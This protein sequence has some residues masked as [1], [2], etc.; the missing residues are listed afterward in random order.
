LEYDVDKIFPLLEEAYAA[1]EGPELEGKTILLKPNI[2][3]DDDPSKAVITHPVF[4]EAVIRFLWSKKAGKIYL[5]DAPAMHAPSFKPRK[6]GIFEMCERTGVEW[7][8]F[9][10]KS[11]SCP[12]PSGKVPITS[13]V[14]E[15][16]YIFSLPKLKT[17]ELMGY[18]G[19]I[20]NSFGLIPHLHKAKQHAFHRSSRSMASFLV[21]LNERFLPNFIFMDAIVAM[22]GPGPGNG[23]PFPLHLL[24]GSTNPLALDIV[25]SKIIGYNPLEIETNAEG[26]KRKRW[27]ASIDEVVVYG[28]KIEEC[29][30]N[31]FALIPKVSLLK[32]STDILLRRI[33]FLRRL[34]RHPVFLKSRC[35]ECKACL[36]ICPVQALYAHPKNQKKIMISHK[37]CIRCF[38]CQE[39]CPNNAIEVR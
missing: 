2:L 24:L 7:V 18:T 28:N 3:F 17:H 27:L 1:A 38:C 11:F 33:P 36:L 34:E 31:D 12:L 13:I 29:V 22:D 21:D 37:K 6:S 30:R 20:K 15:V 8:Y 10:K 5:G 14:E 4:I 16:D 39:V 19:A 23:R 35:I 9:G 32:M 25:A 26:L